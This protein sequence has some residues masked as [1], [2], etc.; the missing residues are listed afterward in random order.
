MVAGQQLALQALHGFGLPVCLVV[1]PEQVEEAVDHQERQ[2]VVHGHP[3]LGGVAHGDG[4]ADHHVAEQRERLHL[5]VGARTGPSRVR[6][7]PA[8][9][10][11][12]VDREREHVGGAR[13]PE[14]LLVQRGDRGLVDEEERH[15]DLAWDTAVLEHGARETG[16]S[17]EFDGVGALLV[18]GVDINCHRRGALPPRRRG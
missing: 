2:L 14:E 11:L 8:R 4:G 18:G 17:I 12:V 13:S 3:V 16:P 6:G 15:L 9:E 7:A 10:R 1:H 5:G